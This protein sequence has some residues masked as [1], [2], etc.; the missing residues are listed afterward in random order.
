MTRVLNREPSFS[1]LFMAHLVIR[2]VRIQEH[3][4]DQPFY[5][6]E[7]RLARALLLPAHFEGEENS[8]PVIPAISQDALADMIGLRCHESASF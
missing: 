8:V 6:A 4:A 5:S 2:N 1:E 7:K 3:L